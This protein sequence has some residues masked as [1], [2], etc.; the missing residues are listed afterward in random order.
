M[1]YGSTASRLEPSDMPSIFI[2]AATTPGGLLRVCSWCKRVAAHNEWDEV[3][4]A[5]ERLGLFADSPPA[6][7]THGMCSACFAR[8]MDVPEPVSS[9]RRPC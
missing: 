3:E 9:G 2:G 4:V 1:A 8:I 6:A 7:I 5:V